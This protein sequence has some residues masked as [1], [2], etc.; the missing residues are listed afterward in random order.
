MGLLFGCI[1]FTMVKKTKTIR[2]WWE[3]LPLFIKRMHFWH[4]SKNL[5]EIMR[6]FHTWKHD[7]DTG[8]RSMWS[9]E[10]Q[11]ELISCPEIRE[12]GAMFLFFFVSLIFR[13]ELF[14]PWHDFC[15]SFT[16]HLVL[17][18]N[19]TERE[20]WERKWLFWLLR[21]VTPKTS[22]CPWKH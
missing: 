4:F 6:L 15:V 18:N 16:L 17:Q 19:R 3:I 21:V 8:Q 9:W 1:H 11:S 20:E 5:K 13:A 12:S 10:K 7:M 22:L 14:F 2:R